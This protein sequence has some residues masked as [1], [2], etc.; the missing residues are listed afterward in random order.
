[1][2]IL[3]QLSQQNL[4]IKLKKPYINNNKSLDNI[5]SLEH[6]LRLNYDVVLKP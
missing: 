5:N 4:L 3:I 1:M 6:T 2:Y